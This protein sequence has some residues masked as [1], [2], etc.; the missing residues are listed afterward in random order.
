MK[1]GI[2]D[3]F[4]YGTLLSGFHHPA[5][6]F[7]SSHFT[8][9]GPARVQGKLY[10]LS[11]YPG[12]VPTNEAVYLEG[13]LYQVNDESEFTYAIG[14]LDDYEGVLVDPPETPLF[15]REAVTVFIQNTTSAAW[16]YWCNLPVS[17]RPLI[18]TGGLLTYWKQKSG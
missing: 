11:E 2:T 13:E 7:V 10:D 8:L 4:V 5:H 16:I 3:L 18:P 17:G 1:T 9:K 15:R 14:Q 6:A 12:A